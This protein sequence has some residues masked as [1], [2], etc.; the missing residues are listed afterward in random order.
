MS[1][2]TGSLSEPAPAAKQLPVWL[3][4]LI[5]L[6]SLI[7]GLMFVVW[8]VRQPPARSL[9][10]IGDLPTPVRRG[11]MPMANITTATTGNV[12]TWRARAANAVMEVRQPKD[13]PAAFAFSYQNLAF[14]PREQTSLRLI[15]IRITT[16]RAVARYLQITDD[17]MARLRQVPVLWPMQVSEADR[18]KMNA[19]FREYQSKGDAVQRAL[20]TELV[21]VGERSLPATR[22]FVARQCQQIKSILTAEQLNRF[23]QMGR[24]RPASPATRSAR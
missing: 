1:E 23:E 7:G 12:T 17:Q 9:V 21:A 18:A 24:P 22:D 4:I 8:Y 10:E 2:I 5:I 15:Y 13:Q 3:N 16:D 11:A 6:V 20:L 14:V 19:L